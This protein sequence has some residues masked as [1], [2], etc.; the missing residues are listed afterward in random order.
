MLLNP[1][2]DLSGPEK[3]ILLESLEKA[4]IFSRILRQEI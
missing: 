3:A 2:S 1:L 4:H